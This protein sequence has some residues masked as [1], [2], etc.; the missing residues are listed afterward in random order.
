VRRFAVAGA[1][2]P[3]PHPSVLPPGDTE[4]FGEAR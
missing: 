2:P 1:P 4:P 3:P